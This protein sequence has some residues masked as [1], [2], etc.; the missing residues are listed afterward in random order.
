[1]SAVELIG[2]LDE[3]FAWDGA[4]LV[5]ESELGPR[6]DPPAALRGAAGTVVGDPGAERWRVVRDPLGLNKLFW[7]EGPDGALRIAARPSAL[8]ERGHALDEI[9]AIPRGTMVDIGPAQSEARVER[10]VPAA[11]SAPTADVGIEAAGRKIR[12]ALDAYLAGLADRERGASAFICL[13][14]GLDSTGI[15]TLVAEHFPD[16]VGVSFDL[17]LPGAG[18]SEDRVAAVRAAEDFGLPLLEA[19]VTP[20]RLLEPLDT[21]LREGIDWRD[22]NVHAALVNAALAAAIAD[23]APA[24]AAKPLVFTGDLANEFLVDYHAEHYGGDTYYALPRLPPVQLRTFLVRGLDSCHREIGVFQSWGLR[25]IQPYAVA[26][27]TYMQLPEP[28]LQRP[29]RKERLCR[30]IFGPALP[31]HVLKRPKARA[32]SGG[33]DLSGGVLA[34]CVDR[35]VDSAELRRRFARLHDVDDQRALDRFIRAGVYRSALPTIGAPA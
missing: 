31:E 18:P 25:L 34:V 4:R 15:A 33:A 32:Q 13:S 30:A 2:E 1:M 5:G 23:A 24:R 26:V 20:E 35:G 16:A 8:T 19:T 10:T 22:F 12:D 28:F 27:D 21:V 14:G 29:D 3:T 11:W 9:A 17:A 6:N 7:S